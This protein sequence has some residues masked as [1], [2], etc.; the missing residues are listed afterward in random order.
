MATSRAESATAAGNRSMVEVAALTVGAVFLL[1]GVLGFV[2]GIV[3]DFDRMEFAG[4]ESGAKLLGIFQ[5]SILHNVVHLLFGVAGV[6]AARAASVSRTFLI[7]GGATYGLL[8]VYGMVIEK[9]SDADFVPLNRADDWLHFALAAGMIVLGI[10]LG[11]R[12]QR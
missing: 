6:L 1:V 8:F 4:H 5:V 11:T 10:A 7:G 3:Q 9:G 12:T 2:P